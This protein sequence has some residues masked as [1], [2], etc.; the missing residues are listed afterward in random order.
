MGDKSAM[1]RYDVPIDV[2]LPGLG[3]GMIFAVF[4][5]MGMVFV[6]SARL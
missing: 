2:S 5:V 1:G 4:Q 3:I 6:L